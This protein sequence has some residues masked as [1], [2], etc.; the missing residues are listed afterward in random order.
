MF[1]LMKMENTMDTPPKNLQINVP[2]PH[3][4]RWIQTP[5]PGLAEMVTIPCSRL[6]KSEVPD[7]LITTE[8]SK[9]VSKECIRMPAVFVV[10]FPSFLPADRLHFL[11]IVDLN[12]HKDD[13]RPGFEIVKS[14][15]V[16]FPLT[17]LDFVVLGCFQPIRW[18]LK[19]TQCRIYRHLSAG[20]QIFPQLCTKC[21]LVLW[22]RWTFAIS[23]D[24]FHCCRRGSHVFLCGQWHH[25]LKNRKMF[26]NG[27]A[28]WKA[29]SCFF[30]C[31][32]LSC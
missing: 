2:T 8:W 17:F 13:E 5:G 20:L 32:L 4:S 1:H 31:P 12:I 11:H 25:V 9:P 6:R 24:S 15:K 26:W 14:P 29:F 3:G 18:S 10:A 28:F 19:A 27:L 22:L 21:L 30:S 16:E 23:G 7:I